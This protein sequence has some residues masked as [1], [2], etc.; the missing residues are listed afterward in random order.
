MLKLKAGE[1]FVLIGAVLIVAFA[2]LV[3]TIIYVKPPPVQFTYFE[4]EATKLGEAVYR[5]QGCAA[6]HELFGNGTA[7]FGPKLDGVGSRRNT[8]WLKRYLKAPWAGVSEKKYRLKMPPVE[9]MPER[10]FNAL[11]D[12]LS[13]LR[14][15]SVNGQPVVPPSE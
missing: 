8:D 5:S 13:A 6:C 2:A 15:L 12:Y 3:G 11:V 7:A 10:E 9:N 4:S 14:K 1:W